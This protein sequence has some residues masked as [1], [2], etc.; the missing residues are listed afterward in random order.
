MVIAALGTFAILLTA[1]IAAPSEDRRRR[2]ETVAVTEPRPM[3]PS[4]RPA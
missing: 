1:W 3:E 2:R 4:P